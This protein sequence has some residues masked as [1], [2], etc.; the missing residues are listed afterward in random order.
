LKNRIILLIGKDLSLAK[1]LE[2]YFA[3]SEFTITDILDFN[4]ALIKIQKKENESIVLIDVDSEENLKSI[5]A[6]ETFL[7]SVDFPIIF[8]S[9][10]DNYDLPKRIE[11]ISPFG[12]IYKNSPKAVLLSSLTMTLKLCKKIQTLKEKEKSLSEKV[13]LLQNILDCSTDY[14]F[15]KDKE[16]RTILCNEMVA[17]GVG[18]KASD[19]IGHNDIENGVSIELVKGNP[20]KGIRGYENDDLAALRGETISNPNDFVYT[21]SQVY[22]FDTV[23][24]PLRNQNGEI[25]G[26]LGISREITERRKAEKIIASERELLAV[27]LHSIGDGVISTDTD[28][29]IVMMNKAAQEL[30]GWNSSEAIGVP[31]KGIFTIVDEISKISIENPVDKVLRTKEGIELQDPISL[32]TRTGKEM[33]ISHSANPMLDN[34]NKIIGVVLVFRDMTEKIKLEATIQR[35]QKLESIG[36]L[37]GGIA[38][39]FNNLLAGIFGY[40]EIAIIYSKDNPT[41]AEYLN[42]SLSVFN[43]AKALTL[44]LL[45]FSKG[46]NP[47]KRINALT[48]ILKAGIQFSLSGSNISIQYELD[49]N[50]WMVEIDENQ[51]SQVIDNIA[52]NAQQAMPNGGTLVVKTENVTLDNKNFKINKDFVKISFQD[53]GMGI[54]KEIL[55][56]IFDPF[57]ST[58]EKGTGLGLMTVFSIIQKHGGFLDVESTEGKGS[59]FTIYLPGLRTKSTQS[60]EKKES[61]HRG[62][63]KILIM[64]DEK[65]IQEITAIRMEKMGYIVSLAK[66]GEEA[67]Q[68]FSEA[69]K[70]GQCFQLVIL[71]LTIPGGMGGIQTVEEIRKIN[72]TV[73]VIIASGYSESPAISN[74]TNYGFNASLKKPYSKEELIKILDTFSL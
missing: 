43:R 69:E 23:K 3:N 53:S 63:A 37:A 42:K 48:P 1:T 5:E 72:T 32:I 66:H 35:N 25:I 12:V 10:G 59:T 11:S 22:V 67:I 45:T 68:I 27:T 44:Q 13:D 4:S 30:T 7:Q 62:N 24:R 28:G 52:L 34:E 47:I 15:V 19:L 70:S 40:L 57:F 39:D 54:P 29:K 14:I 20:E 2:D 36:I 60:I 49:E 73:P 8:L 31:L 18:K 55:P 16:L 56:R 74:P 17:K 9:N 38:H 26:L 71:D 6:A 51:I 21:D 41:I 61:S 58:K 64:D 46:G 50:L 65:Y 33:I